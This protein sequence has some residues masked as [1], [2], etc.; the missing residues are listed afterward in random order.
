MFEWNWL[1]GECPRLLEVPVLA[2][3][4]DNTGT[5]TNVRAYVRSRSSLSLG[6]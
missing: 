4:G 1:L 5:I 3:Y 6:D 2:C